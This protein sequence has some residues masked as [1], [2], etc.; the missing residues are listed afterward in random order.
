MLKQSASGRVGMVCIYSEGPNIWVIVPLLTF[1]A[2]RSAS[3]SEVLSAIC[4]RGAVISS[5]LYLPA[6]GA[7]AG[8]IGLRCVDSPGTIADFRCFRCPALENGKVL[9]SYKG[10]YPGL[11]W[12]A[13]IWPGGQLDRAYL[14][15]W[16]VRTTVPLK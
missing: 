6:A 2:A 16:P 3:L 11:D 13:P 9:G 5:Q 4:S 10:E 14:I 1:I 8:A 12:W 7:S 15:E